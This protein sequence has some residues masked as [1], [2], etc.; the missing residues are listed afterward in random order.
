MGAV[1]TPLAGFCNRCEH[2]Y[3]LTPGSPSAV[4]SGAHAQ[5]ATALT[6]A[7]PVAPTISSSGVAVT[8]GNAYTVVITV[9][10]GTMTGNTQINGISTGQTTGTFTVHPGQQ[11]DHGLLQ[12]GAPKH[13]RPP[14]AWPSER[15]APRPSA[16]KSSWLSGMGRRWSTE[17]SPAFASV[18]AAI[19]AGSRSAASS[20]GLIVIAGVRTSVPSANSSTVYRS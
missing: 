10:G 8:N 2:H 19:T 18:T 17:R 15:G 1:P 9:S 16:Y 11:H 6:L 3:Q 20:S 14:D 12:L 4:L 5:G 13:E 7:T